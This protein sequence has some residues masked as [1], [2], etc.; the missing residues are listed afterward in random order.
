MRAPG[1]RPCR[2]GCGLS[3]VLLPVRG[4]RWMPFDEELVPA[5][6]DTADLGHIPVKR[7]GVAVLA[8]AS[9]LPARLLTGPP[10]RLMLHRCTAYRGRGVEQLGALVDDVLGGAR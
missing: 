8:P 6:A 4:G 9:E 3:I 1:G 10:W 2:E 5:E 7:E